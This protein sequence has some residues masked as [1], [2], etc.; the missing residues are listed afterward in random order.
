ML[1]PKGVSVDEIL[2]QF[3]KYQTA[4]MK[5]I[6]EKA[7]L[8]KEKKQTEKEE[9]KQ[10]GSSGNKA[11]DMRVDA[12]W[13]HIASSFPDLEGLASVMKGIMTIPHSSAP[14]ERVFS[15]VK[16]IVT[17]Q[18]S[19]LSQE[20]TEALLVLKSQPRGVV[21]G[22]LEIKDSELPALKSSYRL[23]RKTD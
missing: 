12:L 21:A 18:R 4:D 23:S 6:L 16:K 10:S 20:T 5:P 11:Q 13:N 14:C 2:E 7:K 8:E 1:L 3:S 19:C 15:K 17:D 22:N 9:N